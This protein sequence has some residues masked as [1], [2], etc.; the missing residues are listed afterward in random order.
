MI[1]PIVSGASGKAN[2]EMFRE[3]S[4]Q[5]QNANDQVSKFEELRQKMEVQEMTG[6]QKAGQDFKVQQPDQ[7][8]EIQSTEKLN[9]VDQAQKTGEIPKITDLTDL[10]G[11]VDR[12]KMGQ[13]R[14]KDLIA[15]CTSGRTFSPQEMIGLQAEISTIT[16][17]VQLASKIVEQG[18]SGIKQT[19]Q[20]QV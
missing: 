11:V 12:L 14:L 6:P 7:A 13:S 3:A 19:M 20:M 2:T 10:Q 17:E 5:L 9:P 16:T 1:D 8:K 18:V 4:K 15:D